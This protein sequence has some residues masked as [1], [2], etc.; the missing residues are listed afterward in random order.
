MTGTT[1][2]FTPAGWVGVF[3]GAVGCTALIATFTLRTMRATRPDWIVKRLHKTG[4]PVTLKLS[5]WSSVQGGFWDP[6]YTGPQPAFHQIYEAGTG[7]YTLDD[8]G[9]VHPTSFSAMAMSVIAQ[10]RCLTS[11]NPHKAHKRARK[12]TV[13]PS[14]HTR[15]SS[16]WGRS[17]EWCWPR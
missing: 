9:A 2:T 8:A 1:T 4:K 14:A 6:G 3:I 5:M 17:S 16:C 11:P 13:S 10:V 15:S 7:T 12:L